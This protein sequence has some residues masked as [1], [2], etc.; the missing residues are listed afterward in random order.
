MWKKQQKDYGKQ[1]ERKPYQ[2]VTVYH[3]NPHSRTGQRNGTIR[4]R[5]DIGILNMCNIRAIFKQ[6]TRT[7]I[8]ETIGITLH[9]GV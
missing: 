8:L 2:K 3:Q 6:S 4:G 5:T 1:L 7:A 9:H